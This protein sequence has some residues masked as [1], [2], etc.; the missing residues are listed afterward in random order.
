M[1][2]PLKHFFNEQLVRSIAEDLHDA[3][4]PLHKRRFV[5]ACLDYFKIMEIPEDASPD[6]G[7]L[8]FE[9]VKTYE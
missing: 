9:H 2:E 8:S 7:V 4:P 5:A 1:A 6:M 3:Y